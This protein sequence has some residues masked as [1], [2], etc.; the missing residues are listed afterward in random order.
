MAP[1]ALQATW[2]DHRGGPFVDGA[3]ALVEETKPSIRWEIGIFL[4]TCGAPRLCADCL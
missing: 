1:R 2:T 3:Q 4:A